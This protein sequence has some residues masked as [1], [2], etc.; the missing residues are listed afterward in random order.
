LGYVEY[1]DT[2]LEVMKSSGQ[3]GRIFSILYVADGA[4][5][6]MKNI[7]TSVVDPY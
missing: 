3:E 4:L 6:K 2:I 7:G 1:E 5:N